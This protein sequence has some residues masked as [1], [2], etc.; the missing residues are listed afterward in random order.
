MTF[1]AQI[2]ESGSRYGINRS[3]VS[4]LRII[5]SE[6]KVVYDYERGSS[7]RSKT[8][9]A[10]ELKNYIVKNARKLAGYRRKK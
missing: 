2:Y 3:P 4:R 6:G 1:Q 8:K 9:K 5:N 10:T 7:V